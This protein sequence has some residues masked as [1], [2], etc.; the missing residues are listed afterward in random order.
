[1]SPD[2][3][4]HFA[5][6]SGLVVPRKS[7]SQMAAWPPT[8]T[9]FVERRSGPVEFESWGPHVHSVLQ[10]E[11]CCDSQQLVGV[12]PSIIDWLAHPISLASTP[13][14]SPANQAGLQGGVAL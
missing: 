11:E 4:G 7:R 13:G 14:S 2:S 12:T 5:T 8:A 3:F 1:M 10:P 9:A 6:S